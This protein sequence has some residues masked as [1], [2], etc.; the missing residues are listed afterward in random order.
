MKLVRTVTLSNDRLLLC[1]DSGIGMVVDGRDISQTTKLCLGNGIKDP[2]I[3]NLIV[4][5][6]ST[7]R[8]CVDIGATFGYVTLL[9]A[10][11]CLKPGKVFSFEPH[12][13]NF[14]LLKHSVEING[15]DK[16]CKV[17]PSAL[18]AVTGAKAKLY[19]HRRRFECATLSEV[20]RKSYGLT[21]TH[22]RKDDE[23]LVLLSLDDIMAQNRC[24][25]DLI[26]LSAEG[27]EHEVWAGMRKLLM[28][29]KS[30]TI[31]LDFKPKWYCN[32]EKFASDIF[33]AGFS[34]SRLFS[35]G[36]EIVENPE[37]LLPAFRSTLLL[38]R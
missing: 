13:A 14:Q 7:R 22:P 35:G 28:A 19:I 27:Y 31:L 26:Y 15:F 8:V 21:D 1:Y 20:A 18:G 34:V 17:Y 32:L 33:D 36:R 25:P 12:P 24:E 10:Q 9:M 29:K 5:L 2:E 11:N 23:F 38:T 16:Y 6:A 3:T 4:E 30:M 37:K